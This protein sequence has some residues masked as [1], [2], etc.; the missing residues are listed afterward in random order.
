M[1]LIRFLL[2]LDIKCVYNHHEQASA[3]AAEAYARVNNKIAVVCVTSGPG[4]INAL[5]GVAGA[6]LDSIPMLIISGQAKCSMNARYRHLNVRNLGIQD[7]NIIST[8]SNMTKYAVMVTEPEKIRYYLE[9]AYYKA[10]E[11]RP[12]P[13]WLDI[14]VD[15]QGS[16]V[17]ESILQGFCEDFDKKKEKKIVLD[18]EIRQIIKRL[19]MAERPI[20]YAGNGIRLA[21]ASKD[22]MSMVE[23]LKVPVVTTW[24]AIDLIE[25]DNLYFAGRAGT[26]GDR[27]GNFAVQN[28]DFVLAIGNR[29]NV[30]QVGYV[31]VDVDEEEL[32]KPT[33]RVDLPIC[34]DAKKFIQKMLMENYNIGNKG[35]WIEKCN[36][37]KLT[38]P[39]V[40]PKHYNDT[41]PI[42]V[43]AFIDRL[44]R[45]LQEQTKIVVANGS[46]S[47]VGSQAFYIKN[48][49][50]FIM[51]CGL[52]SM[53]YDLP[54]A[55]GVSV[56]SNKETVICVTG[57]G[58]IQ[59]NLQELQTIVTNK[60]P[61]KIFIINNS[62]YQ[63]IR[64]T[65][66]NLFGNGLVGVGPESKD[67][68]FP[69]FEKIAYAYDIPYFS[70]SSL[71]AIDEI[72]EIVKKE[73]SCCICEVFCTTK[74]PF[75]PK[76]ATKKL[77]DGT[78]VSRP[79]EDLS[80][81]LDREELK[82]NMYVDLID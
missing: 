41:A 3:I 75:E 74:Q 70:I 7:F 21:N 19:S 4:A 56:A 1:E 44:S 54:A 32:S 61:I 34:C 48:G 45:N 16:Y 66:N 68:D 52:S 35:A 38:Y 18:N 39:V 51:N 8:V 10:Y 47:V 31:V 33:I 36:Q 59:M 60:L 77:D 49:Q 82:K 13:C 46:A 12:G 79:L 37:W 71:D 81:F 50:R 27:A 25:N 22:F 11:G 78:L 67:L 29:L 24:N 64:L 73:R 30:N 63:Q 17:E 23:R 42:N 62:G 69:N 15:I 2:L 6:Y 53:G 58:S 72:I 43:Y 55:I 28:S 5:N 26:M 14:P 80:P 9:Q 76:S 65:Q 20:I 57:D 40:L